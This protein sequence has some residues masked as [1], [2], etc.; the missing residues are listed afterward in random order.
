MHKI[1][2]TSSRLCGVSVARLTGRCE[3]VH[4]G[5]TAAILAGT[6]PSSRQTPFQQ[7][8]KLFYVHSLTSMGMQ[9]PFGMTGRS[10]FTEA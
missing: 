10:L 3:Y 7:L 4:V 9:P 8:S 2:S 6:C 5:L 1:T